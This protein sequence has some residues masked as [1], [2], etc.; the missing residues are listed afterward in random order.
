[1][2][3][4]L[5]DAGLPAPCG[6]RRRHQPARRDRRC[7]RRHRGGLGGPGGEARGA[8]S[9]RGRGAP[10]PPCWPRT[11]RACASP[12]SRRRCGTASRVVALHFWNPA[13][14]MP[15]V[16]VAGGEH[17]A[18]DRV[19]EA[20]ELVRAIGKVPVVLHH[21][22]LGFLGTRM[23]QAVVREAIAPARRRRRLGR[24]HRPGRAHELR[25]PLPGDRP[26]GVG[27]PVRP[28]RDRR[29]PRLPAARP[30]PVDGAA[31]R[32]DR[33]RRARRDS[34]RR[35]GAGSTSG[36]RAGWPRSSPVAIASS[37][38]ACS[39][40]R[41]RAG[42]GLGSDEAEPVRLPR[43]GHDRRV[44]GAAGGA[45]RRGEAARR[46]A[47][48]RAADEPAAGGAVRAG[49][50]ERRRRAGGRPRRR[51]TRSRSAR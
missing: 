35:P 24:R 51:A 48:P 21:E 6:G 27:R 16:E 20:T 40:S 9:G 22:V 3:R 15:I 45:R 32:P 17:A 8:R 18:A 43:A 41:P 1:M 12:T 33:A 31:A 25:D 42:G 49:R 26:A 37:C 29:D 5:G 38:G 2:A 19:A 13:H 7:R 46:R 30:R 11:R 44:R 4:F 14:L 47:E 34:A 50:P 28:R 36:R 39:W 23:Q 10:R